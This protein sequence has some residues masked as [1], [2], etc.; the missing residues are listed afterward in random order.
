MI[1]LT[2]AVV[3]YS[4][5]KGLFVLPLVGIFIF[6]FAILTRKGATPAEVADRAEAILN[7]NSAGWDIDDYE[8]LNPK[9]EEL[10]DL[11]RETI[12]IGGLPEAWVRLDDRRKNEL[13][14]IIAKI[15]RS[16]LRTA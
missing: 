8:H 1:G 15:R 5:A 6:V 11:W 7:G 10:N 13:R 2:L 12:A 3:L 4:R 14:E 9:S 16:A